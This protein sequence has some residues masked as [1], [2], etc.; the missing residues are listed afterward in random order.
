[1][2]SYVPIATYRLQLT[3][4]F[5][6]T[7][8][9]A[10][11]PYLKQLGISHLYA[12]PFL[13]ARAGSTHGYDI[14]DHSK[15]SDDL[16]GEAGFAILSGALRDAGIGLILDF[17][18]NHMGVGHADNAW[19]LDVLEWGEASPHAASFDIDWRGLPY[20]TQP[21][22]LLPIL[23]RPY[24]E[25]LE[26]GEIALRFDAETGSF[27]AW[28]FDHKLPINPRRYAEIIRTAVGAA[29]AHG[30]PA[31]QAL[32]GL[33]HEHRDPRAPSYDAAP[34]LKQ[35]L[36]TLPGAVEIISR[37][38]HAYNG[39]NEESRLA[40][41][42]LLERQNY[43]L[44]Y[45]R[46]AFSAINYRRFFDINDLAGIRPEH[47][48]TFI[49]MH[50]LVARLIADGQ[51]QGIRLDH[52]DGLRDPAQYTRRLLELTRR[53][54]PQVRQ[55]GFY[56]LVEKILGDGEHMPSLRGVDGTTG[57]ERL[58]L[59]SRVLLDDTGLPRLD[60][61]WRDFAG[62][63]AAFADILHASKLRVLDTMLASEFTVLT[64]ALARI[65]AGHFS[66]RDFT[67]DRLRAALQ[68]YVLEFPVYR[69]YITAAR[70][71]DTDRKLIDGVIARA[72]DAW[73][74]P[75]P[76]I[77][78]FL[79]D[80]ITTD[81]A[82]NRAYSTPRVRNFALKLQQF[83]GPLMAKSLEDTAFY[84]YP[85]LLALN[86]VGGDPAAAALDVAGFHREQMRLRKEMPHGLTTTATHDT[87]RG[88][89]AR[90]RILA[91]AEITDDWKA[92]VA[93][94]RTLNAPLVRANGQSRAPTCS[95]PSAQRAA[96]WN[97][98]A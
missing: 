93:E 45:W 66:S 15:L 70:I 47:P 4:D 95:N 10:L 46:V 81:L 12:S 55:N 33:A 28:Y 22:V 57:Y 73:G 86:E 9:A 1:M 69:T 83:T 54:R 52:I 94:W 58:N 36:A 89:D 18:P 88:E 5:D 43:H 60:R 6:F 75:D 41:H 84:R 37:G 44:A 90:M 23:G 64:R 62:E 51:L 65:A 8:A 56:I 24:G 78:D 49:A 74:G 87:K 14:V 31:G 79:R 71:S 50:V 82:R 48:A 39:D 30:E 72:R 61:I 11:V 34:A 40:L 13:Q 21:G 76:E 35:R 3:K 26:A 63:R 25:A 97:G 20:R 67:L 42:R 59:I 92:A 96:H 19:W 91:L 68:A 2:T 27:A 98:G 80:A 17:V 32:I 77:F 29:G 53:A 38:L 85:R 16:G 7:Q